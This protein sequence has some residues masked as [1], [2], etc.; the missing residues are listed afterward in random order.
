MKSILSFLA[1]VLYA[2]GALSQSSGPINTPA[3]NKAFYY[4]G[5][6]PFLSTQG[7]ITAACASA[8]VSSLSHS[9]GTGK[10]ILA[11]GT[12]PSDSA[13]AI[14]NMSGC[15]GVQVEDQRSYPTACYS[16][17]SSTW[18]LAQCG[19]PAAMLQNPTATQVTTVPSG[20]MNRVV[21]SWSDI[22]TA[23]Y[24]YTVTPLSSTGGTGNTVA[25]NGNFAYVSVQGNS[26]IKIYNVSTG[27]PQAAGSYTTACTSPSGITFSNVGGNTVAS[28]SCYD[29]KT[30]YTLSVNAATGALTALGSVV[31]SSTHAPWPGMVALGTDLLIPT[32]SQCPA[33]SVVYKVSL[34]T[35]ASPSVT[36]NATVQNATD[37]SQQCAAYL[38]TD[39]TYVYAE[40]SA[41]PGIG[42]A[43]VLNPATMTWVGTPYSLPHSPQQLALQGN[44]LYVTVHD[45]DAVYA[46]DIS[47][48]ASLATKGSLTL[49]S[50]AALPVVAQG[51]RLYVGCDGAGAVV[52]DIS[53]PASM[54]QLTSL[55]SSFSSPQN[56]KV[57]GR[58]LYLV[59]GASNGA[60]Y[61]F[62][63]G[64]GYFDTVSAGEGLFRYLTATNLNARV[65][66][67]GTLT[68]DTL[69]AG[70]GSTATTQA[71]ND[72]ST[73]LATTA[74]VDTK[75]NSVSV[76]GTTCTLGSSCT[77]TLTYCA[78]YSCANGN[79]VAV[80]F[81]AGSY[82]TTAAVATTDT[83]I[84]GSFS[85]IT[86]PAC[87]QISDLNGVESIC[88][89]TATSTTLG[90]VHRAVYNGTMRS[91]VSGATVI[92]YTNTFGTSISTKLFYYT[93]ANSTSTIVYPQT[94][95]LNTGIVQQLSGVAASYGQ[96]TA[97]G[98]Q[99]AL[100]GTNRSSGPYIMNGYY[101]NGSGQATDGCQWQND[102][103]SN[104]NNA[105]YSV[106][107][108]C[109]GSSGG[110]QAGLSGYPTVLNE[111][112]GGGTAPTIA[113]TT[114]TGT[115][116]PGSTNYAGSLTVT[117]ASGALVFTYTLGGTSSNPAPTHR[118]VCRPYDATN[119]VWGTLSSVTATGETV[120]FSST[121]NGAVIDWTGCGGY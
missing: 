10:V 48:P 46:L 45:S 20:S 109:A 53:N 27:Y 29:N 121:T 90:S 25:L 71:A 100:N 68:V 119:N 99:S 86:A 66:S 107:L 105:A 40:T 87:G 23:T 3:L 22:Y 63:T 12:V 28:V 108:I 39:G 19:G 24:P 60:L 34:A 6:S 79:Q 64:G 62:D 84:T 30:L 57:H 5:T 104:A 51:T 112:I 58:N 26:V 13:T 88:W 113:F 116:G 16:Y 106:D 81:S 2:L 54:S 83:T 42:T 117:S 7:T 94:A 73:R 59:G 15:T 61:T 97:A 95:N 33:T 69:K 43:Q 85:G 93:L 110:H 9:A 111:V 114:G 75:P 14:T 80:S 120:T 35:P 74:Y 102:P 67:I 52:L 49:S 76:N 82:P 1:C 56:M 91:F 44:T 118:L 31:V 8:A 96:Y 65:G 11:P 92:G 103:V 98:G 101:W 70:Y 21:G 37:S 18:T 55:G 115:V 41:E 36:G 50:C 38:A 72:N 47:N 78:G 17:V 77:T 4:V 89:D 32:D